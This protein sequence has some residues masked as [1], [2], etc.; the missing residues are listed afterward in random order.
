MVDYVIE[1]NQRCPECSGVIKITEDYNDA[2]CMGC[3]EE[4]L[5]K[6]EEEVSEEELTEGYVETEEEEIELNDDVVEADFTVKE[7]KDEVE[8]SV[9]LSE[10][11]GNLANDVVELLLKNEKFSNLL[12]TMEE[13]KITES[14]G[15]PYL[16][17]SRENLMMEFLLTGPHALDEIRGSLPK[18]RGKPPTDKTLKSWV[19]AFDN[20]KDYK[21]IV[22]GDL[23]SIERR[24]NE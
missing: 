19:M 3:G 6:D 4:W 8:N 18:Q 15:N 23:F 10:L 1:Y 7:E 13:Q 12:G 20:L 24:T 9:D 11:A 2:K 21:V 17:G 16:E 5:L 22:D 14:Y